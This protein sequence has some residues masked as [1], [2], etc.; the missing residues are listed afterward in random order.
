MKRNMIK[1]VILFMAAVVLLVNAMAQ[2][3]F[4][5][6]EDQVRQ[7]ERAIQ[8]QRELGATEYECGVLFV[9]G[10]EAEEA[11]TELNGW[12]A[13][14]GYSQEDIDAMKNARF[15]D[16]EY[17]YSMARSWTRKRYLG[18]FVSTGMYVNIHCN[19]DQLLTDI[20]LLARN[21]EK[22]Q[23]AWVESI[24]EPSDGDILGDANGD[25]RINAQDY[26]ILKRVVL[27]THTAEVPLSNMDVNGDGHIN[28]IDYI[29]LKRY[30]LNN[31]Q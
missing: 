9:E 5:Y 19:N 13:S 28:A 12:F 10:I 3:A 17:D 7:I 14:L 18:I 15:G 30:I 24:L 22:V 25:G 29:L 4:A 1:H 6:D 2:M 8:E 31:P 21:S 11:E 16:A 27:K 26:L 20:V 23:F